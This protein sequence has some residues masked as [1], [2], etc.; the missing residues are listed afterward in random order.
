M[1]FV[2]LFLYY[3]NVKKDKN[4]RFHMQSDSDSTA[5]TVQIVS[6][7]RID[8]LAKI[9]DL[10]TVIPLP[11]QHCKPNH[12]LVLAGNICSV[13]NARK[14]RRLYGLLRWCN[15]HFHTVVFVPGESEYIHPYYKLHHTKNFIKTK[16][17]SICKIYPNVRLLDED[18]IDVDGVRFIGAFENQSYLAE[19]LQIAPDEQTTVIISNSRLQQCDVWIPLLPQ[20]DLLQIPFKESYIEKDKARH[21]YYLEMV[22]LDY[23]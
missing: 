6:D 18:I 11:S 1:K 5:L 15:Y 13:Y 19:Q 2:I 7:L 20:D 22:Y 14:T 8:L 3:K 4:Q 10:S 23:D 17:Q 16:L 21:K 9:P 12:V